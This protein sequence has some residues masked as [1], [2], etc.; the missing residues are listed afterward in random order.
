MNEIIVFTKKV[1]EKVVIHEQ[2]FFLPIICKPE[3]DKIMLFNW[4]HQ[5]VSAVNIDLEIKV[6]GILLP[7]STKTYLVN[8]VFP[9]CTIF[10]LSENIFDISE[11]INYPFI[12]YFAIED[13][14]IYH[15]PNGKLEI[16][17]KI[18]DVFGIINPYLLLRLTLTIEQCKFKKYF[19][20]NIYEIKDLKHQ[21]LHCLMKI[22]TE[23]P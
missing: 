7:K 12:F 15:F 5:I 17:C 6:F 22:Y 11:S 4:L 13:P 20:K 19:I 10:T 1:I 18:I 3:Q 21:F 8:E 14:F 16:P 23:L 9:N 2:S